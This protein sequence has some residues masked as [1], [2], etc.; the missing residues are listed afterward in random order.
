MAGVQKNAGDDDRFTIE[1]KLTDIMQMFNTFD[2]APFYEKEL[3]SNA[4]EYIV[5]T[6]NDEATKKAIRLIIQYPRDAAECEHARD[7]ENAIRTHF[8]NKS[9]AIDR[10]LRHEIR[11]G[12]IGLLIAITFLTICLTVRQALMVED[13]NISPVIS[14]GLLIV[15]WV[16]LWNPV[17]TFL[18]GLYPIVR[19]RNMYH[20]ISEME[21]DILPL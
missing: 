20:R 4:E 11:I 17:D 14:E 9:R 2:P 10:Q 13:P 16:V 12:Q 21:I 3:D 6:V 15:G 7:L 1:I 19:E 5:S 8:R 18:Y